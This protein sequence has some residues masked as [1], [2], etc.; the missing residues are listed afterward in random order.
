MSFGDTDAVA[1]GFL[2]PAIAATADAESDEPGTRQAG[3]PPPGSPSDYDDRKL[4]DRRGELPGEA[5]GGAP[6][7]AGVAA[8]KEGEQGDPGDAADVGGSGDDRGEEAGSGGGV[9]AGGG[10]DERAG[11]RDE[12]VRVFVRCRPATKAERSKEGADALRANAPAANV[13]SLDVRGGKVR[14]E[15]DHVF[16]PAATQE[17]V[18]D[19]LKG[20]IAA[21]TEGI[22]CTVFA[23][24]QTGTGKTHTM[25]GKGVEKELAA[26]SGDTR[27][28][29][30]TTKPRWGV[31]PRAV[32]LL[33]SSLRDATR[34]ATR[35]RD[36][37]QVTVHCSYLQIYNE[38]VFD[39]LLD[40]R[41]GRPLPLRE[42]DG[43]NGK[44]VYVSG[45]SEYRVS[46]VDDVM[47]LLAQGS[48]KRAVRATEYNEASSRSHAILQ[49][50]VTVETR[51]AGAD[52]KVI[53]RAKL[54]LVDLAGSEKWDTNLR[55]DAGRTK[56]LT[57]IKCVCRRA[58]SGGCVADPACVR[59]CPAANLSQPWATASQPSLRSEGCTFRTVTPPSRACY[60]ILWEATHGPSSSLRCAQLRAPRRRARQPWPSPTER[61]RSWSRFRPMRWWT[62]R[63]CSHGPVERFRACAR[64][65]TASP[66]AH[67][68][69]CGPLR[70]RPA[71]TPPARCTEWGRGATMPWG[72]SR[73]PPPVGAP[74]ASKRT[75]VLLH[76]CRVRWTTLPPA[77]ARECLRRLGR[78]RTRVATATASRQLPRAG[79]GAGR[80]WARP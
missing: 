70:V 74:R 51:R 48:R 21:V 54:S 52:R 28:L 9:A 27:T 73:G 42:H 2:P 46:T 4:A 57:A 77:A 44:E 72:G 6:P 45:L 24:G 56:E 31:I 18:F 11:A 22:N 26:S 15:Y 32:A 34:E 12:P 30:E 80:R 78:R 60:K 62:T 33:L 13:V 71:P 35:G 49:L 55:L 39:L 20:S 68:A 64:S 29:S 36:E 7:D 19:E 16:G 3:T 25:L 63:C 66:C 75:C 67:V 58:A 50:S 61:G 47:A 5:A 23:Y 59:A 76:A 38:K 17:Q 8:G 40:S 69:V 41:E 1:P 14:C 37:R 43:P 10:K 65:S 79:G 53:R